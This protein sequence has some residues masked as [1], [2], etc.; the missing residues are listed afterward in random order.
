M[1]EWSRAEDPKRRTKRGASVPNAQVL[2]VLFGADTTTVEGP[3]TIQSW[4]E[5]STLLHA[6]SVRG[7]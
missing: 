7:L 4:L 2:V 5:G 6:G 1:I 3:Y